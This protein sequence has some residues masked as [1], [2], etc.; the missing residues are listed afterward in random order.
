MEKVTE[1]KP[2]LMDVAEDLLQQYGHN[3]SSICVVFPN[4]R[5]RLFLSHYLGEASGGKP[6]LAPVY[7]TISELVQEISGLV[8]ADKMQLIFELFSVYQGV[9]GKTE[10]LDDFYYYSEVLLSDFED[11]DK[12]LVNARDLFNNLSEQKSIEGQFEYLSENQLNAI[13]QFWKSF[14]SKNVSNDQKDFLKFWDLLNDIYATF[15]LRLKEKKLAYEGMI[16]RETA[17]KIKGST[18]INLAFE[19]YIFIGFNALNKCE[20]V[21]FHYLKKLDKALFYWDYDEYYTHSILHEAGYF[22]RENI[23]RFP[24]GKPSDNCRNLLTIPKSITLLP[25]SSTVAQAKALPAIFEN[26]GLNLDSDFGQTALVLPDEKLMIPVLYSLPEV[27]RDINITMGYPLRESSVF[28]FIEQLYYLH[29]NSINSPGDSTAFLC[30]N[31]LDFLRHPFV[32]S[33]HKD[34]V[35]NLIKSIQETKKVSVPLAVLHQFDDMKLYFQHLQNADGTISYLLNILEK[36]I[37]NL[38]SLKDRDEN[39]LQLEFLYQAYSSINRLSEIIHNNNLE[40]SSHL[41]FRLIR[42]ILNAMTVPFSGEPLAGLQ[43]LGILETRLLD[44]KNVILLSMNEGIMPRSPQLSSFI[45]NNLRFGFGLPIPE[46]HDA[47]YA[48]YFYRLIQ[49][50][51]NVFI[52][53]NENAEGLLT[54]ERSRFV[55]Q[56][57]YDKAFIVKELHLDT[58]I[59]VTVEKPITIQKNN[60]ILEKLNT[61][62]MGDSG[63]WL[64]PSAINEFINCPLKFYF[65]HLVPLK[66]AE[67]V[68]EEVDPLIFGKLV[69]RSMH[70]F[71]KPYVGK[72]MNSDIIKDLIKRDEHLEEIVTKAF[73]REL[74][75][76][77]TQQGK[78]LA[79][80]HLII[81]EIV[82]H[83]LQQILTIDAKNSPFQIIALE[84]KYQMDF[85]VRQYNEIKLIQVGGVIDRIDRHMES[86]RII[87]YKTG[88]SKP[89]FNGT[90]SLFTEIPS[91]RNDAAFQV[92]L[93]AFLCREKFPEARITPCL[94]YL[95]ESYRSDFNLILK[96]QSQKNTGVHD[97][98]AYHHPFSENLK[99]TLER[100]VNPSEP[101]NQTTDLKYCSLCSYKTVCHR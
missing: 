35:D 61:Y 92:F 59:S 51:T 19:Q 86:I 97:F 55:H 6:V 81:K 100:I 88:K 47:I 7:K 101:F 87:D 85:P 18:S 68:T 52:L 53:F 91:K 64:S 95:R 79:G 26:I 66:E 4:K 36:I 48:Y 21:L 25:V 65:H 38:L 77:G 73:Y 56:L 76:S 57:V 33:Y 14:D 16:Y 94:Y 58:S 31:V 24:S 29:K 99:S 20:E 9:T 72:E 17:E 78:E 28:A 44:F 13:M 15:R 5:A 40:F 50:V 60:A 3:L 32:Y 39:K 11:V 96:D 63:S 46:H 34:S 41:L 75:G 90:G 93:Y 10:N 69:H 1:I 42:K 45:P 2:F 71:Y 82:I 74:Y 62:F 43:V 22:V 89:T 83:Y 67:E 12:N 27:I 98:A 8:L 84:E 30:E 49:R 54:G 37:R 70:Q 80:M 23:K